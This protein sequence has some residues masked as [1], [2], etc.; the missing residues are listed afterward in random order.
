MQAAADSVLTLSS[1]SDDGEGRP[2]RLHVAA[3]TVRGQIIPRLLVDE[4]QYL[5]DCFL[6]GVA[7]E[8]VAGHS[9]LPSENPPMG[10]DD[11]SYRIRE[12]K[13]GKQWQEW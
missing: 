11:A 3:P 4:S 8:L 1:R 5:R 12:R 10:D 13:R 6:A 2:A 9:Y 7:R